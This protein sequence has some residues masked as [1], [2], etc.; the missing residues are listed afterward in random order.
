MNVLLML[1][2]A[3]P[4]AG[5]AGRS[6]FFLSRQQLPVDAA[7]GFRGRAPCDVASVRP[8]PA[9]DRGRAQ[10][11]PVDC[12]ADE[13]HMIDGTQQKPRDD[14]VRS[15][16]EFGRVSLPRIFGA[17]IGLTDWLKEAHTSAD[18]LSRRIMWL[19]FALMG[20]TGVLVILVVLQIGLA[21]LQLQ[22]VGAAGAP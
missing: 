15:V 16:S 10:P 5:R 1:R 6:G 11:Q 13:V 9:L 2:A 20:L 14:Y 21:Y 4:L 22:A 18:K 17:I 8:G 19:T 7:G 3:G 12:S